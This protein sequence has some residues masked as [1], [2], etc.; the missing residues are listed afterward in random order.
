M[1]ETLQADPNSNLFSPLAHPSY[2]PDAA[3]SQFPLAAAYVQVAGLDPLRDHA[4]IY[5]RILVE[6]YG[7]N[8]K[9]D[10]YPG[11]GHMYGFL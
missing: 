1:V 9:V 2:P 4:L 5:D 7:I 6:E 10:L 3:P 11:F 8:S